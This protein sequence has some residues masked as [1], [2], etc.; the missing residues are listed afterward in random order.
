MKAVTI[1]PQFVEAFPKPL[2][3]GV[4]Y[5]SAKHGLAAHLCCCGCKTKIVTKLSPVD[6]VLTT[7]KPG[8]VTL[9]PSIGNWNHPCQSHYF[10]RDN[11]VVW[12][13]KMTAPEIA[14]GRALS[15]AARDRYYGGASIDAERPSARPATAEPAIRAPSREGW[16]IR[17]LHWLAGG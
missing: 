7:P 10:I 17:F 15:R 3:E 8:V 4:L 16:I 2:K 11:R 14:R 9:H 13:G 12:V 1:T 5:V 6:W